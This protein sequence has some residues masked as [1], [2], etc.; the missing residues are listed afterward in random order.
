MSNFKILQNNPQ[1]LLEIKK[2]SSLAVPN[3]SNQLSP[4]KNQI[5]KIRARPIKETRMRSKR[6]NS[7]IGFAIK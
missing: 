1:S 5:S 2:R 3:M 6:L 7:Y 4:K